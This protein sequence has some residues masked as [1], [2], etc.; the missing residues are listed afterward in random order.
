MEDLINFKKTLYA[1]NLVYVATPPAIKLCILLMY[2]RIFA[3]REFVLA[4]KIVGSV[5]FIWFLV[6]FLMGIFNCL[7]IDSFWDPNIQGTCISFEYYSIGYAVV[8]ISTDIVILA[9][10][11]RVV[12]N[13][14]LPRGQKIALTLIFMLGSL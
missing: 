5:L 8:N 2:K 7:P 1:F 12:W 13:L 3:T 10:P 9:L 6:C 14:Q 11:I 4:T